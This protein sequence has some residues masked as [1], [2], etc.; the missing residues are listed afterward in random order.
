MRFHASETLEI[1]RLV[2]GSHL[3]IKRTR[4]KLGIT[5]MIAN[6]PLSADL[7]CKSP[8]PFAQQAHPKDAAKMGQ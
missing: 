2:E 8:V 1:V 4:D 3:S 7:L 6:R 5:G